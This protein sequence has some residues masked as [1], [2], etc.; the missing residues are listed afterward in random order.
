[1]ASRLAA[2]VGRALLSE[3]VRVWLQGQTPGTRR[4]LLLEERPST[5]VMGKLARPGSGWLDRLLADPELSQETADVLLQLQAWEAIAGRHPWVMVAGL[6]ARRLIQLS[7]AGVSVRDIDAIAGVVRPQGGA[8]G[9]PKPWAEPQ[10]LESVTDDISGTSVI[11]FLRDL[12][13]FWSTPS[14]ALLD[15]HAG[16]RLPRD[17]DAVDPVRYPVRA[18]I[19]ALRPAEMPTPRSLLRVE[20]AGGTLLPTP[21]RIVAL[22]S[23]AS[24]AQAALC[25]TAKHVSTALKALDTMTRIRAEHANPETLAAAGCTIGSVL[26]GFPVR[27]VLDFEFQP[28]GRGPAHI[29]PGGAYVAVRVAHGYHP[30]TPGRCPAQ[31]IRLAVP[32]RLQPYMGELVRRAT[33]CAARRIADLLGKSPLD[34]VR[35]FLERWTGRHVPDR[36]LHTAFWWVAL[37]QAQAPP[38][39]LELASDRTLGLWRAALSYYS[40][41]PQKFSDILRAAHQVI[42]RWAN[43]GDVERYPPAAESVIGQQ[44]PDLAYIATA[45]REAIPVGGNVDVVALRDWRASALGRRPTAIPC[46]IRPWTLTP[47]ACPAAVVVA[48][49]TLHNGK[50]PRT[51]GVPARFLDTADAKPPTPNDVHDPAQRWVVSPRNAPRKA[52]YSALTDRSGSEAT[53]LMSGHGADVFSAH[54]PY[55]LPPLGVLQGMTADVLDDVYSATGAYEALQAARE[56][57]EASVIRDMGAAEVEDASWGDDAEDISILDQWP[58]ALPDA[59]QL[60]LTNAVGEAMLALPGGRI[61]A[62]RADLRCG[63][64]VALGLSGLPTRNFGRYAAHYATA[65]LVKRQPDQSLHFIALMRQADLGLGAMPVELGRLGPLLEGVFQ[66]AHALQPGGSI[67]DGSPSRR[68]WQFFLKHLRS[69]GGLNIDA[70]DETE[71]TRALGATSEYLALLR[72][73]G[74]LAAGLCDRLLV[75]PNW[76]NLEDLLAL[77]PGP[78]DLRDVRTGDRP[79]EN[80]NVPSGRDRDREEILPYVVHMLGGEGSGWDHVGRPPVLPEWCPTGPFGTWELAKQARFVRLYLCCPSRN[81]VTRLL[82]RLG[83]EK[84]KRPRLANK[85]LVQLRRTG[86][87]KL[88][89]PLRL[90]APGDQETFAKLVLAPDGPLREMPR[91]LGGLVLLGLTFGM[92][93]TEARRFRAAD[94]RFVGQYVEVLARGTKNW[95]ARRQFAAETFVAGA[96]GLGLFAMLRQ[97][98]QGQGD[99]PRKNDPLFAPPEK[100]SKEDSDWLADALGAAFSMFSSRSVTNKWT[101]G[102]LTF[103]GLRHAAILR[104]VQDLVSSGVFARGNFKSCLAS[105]A[106]AAG[107]TLPTTLA[108]YIGTAALKIRWR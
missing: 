1:M 55:S 5:A 72:Y 70:T 41:D 29:D 96:E 105:L 33:E 80:P 31:T 81:N 68:E 103:H 37:T 46:D 93:L 94:M 78:P 107:Q 36:T 20:D 84:A 40:S 100:R 88:G 26:F 13:R 67:F 12:V 57:I 76:Y 65:S 69:H 92:R 16:P 42:F 98:I 90:L 53:D 38:A 64:A 59:R 34:A 79:W 21:P 28:E 39:W 58:T 106:E 91:R 99:R 44:G 66:S 89:R 32:A 43:L 9:L 87:L 102:T 25:P 61:R 54:G 24:R 8:V 23:A 50:K 74:M 47:P 49:K 18:A 62:A 95:R 56:V 14:L 35:G 45:W 6:I 75:P 2:A 51:I 85:I 108:S 60:A 30:Q 97:Q 19:R 22:L 104:A 101:E 10:S 27:E 63:A 83:I 4:K 7:A 82:E 73:G 48:D 52:I 86:G 17:P 3:A 15:E 11:G 77:G 71:V